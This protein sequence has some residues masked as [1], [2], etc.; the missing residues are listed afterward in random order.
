MTQEPVC[1]HLECHRVD[2]TRCGRIA[3][4]A[5]DINMLSAGPELDALVALKIFGRSY[6]GAIPGTWGEYAPRFS[7]DIAQAWR[8]VEELNGLNKPLSL[9]RVA[10]EES[11]WAASFLV[12]PEFSMNAIGTTAPLAICRAALK[13]VGA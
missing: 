11:L 3:V 5:I 9:S 13:A 4:Q 8:V 10:V 6:K 7:D 12:G 1:N 2:P